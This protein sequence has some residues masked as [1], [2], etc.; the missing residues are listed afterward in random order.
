[1]EQ[2][3]AEA[4]SGANV[5]PAP[6]LPFD[7]AKL[8]A[9]LE[10]AGVDALVVSSKHNIQYLLGGYRF[11]FFDHFDAIGVSRYLPLLVY[12]RGRPED[13]AYFGNPME[14]YERRSA[15]S[16]AEVRKGLGLGWGHAGRGRLCPG[17]LA[18]RAVGIGVERPFLPADAEEALRQ[19]SCLRPPARRR[20]RAPRKAAGG[21]DDRTSS[22]FSVRLRSRS[23]NRC[24]R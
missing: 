2:K 17:K 5:A 19:P 9:L 14:R 18:R 1:M 4:A 6:A 13:A 7:A 23:S 12:V 22:P 20:G 24:W 16:D 8:D 21:Q 10:Q 15:S 11:F 3:S